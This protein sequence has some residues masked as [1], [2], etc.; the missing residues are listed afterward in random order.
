MGEHNWSAFEV[1]VAFNSGTNPHLQSHRHSPSTSL[2]QLLKTTEKE[3]K[4]KARAEK[5]IRK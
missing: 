1:E 3:K 2:V 5:E 4:I